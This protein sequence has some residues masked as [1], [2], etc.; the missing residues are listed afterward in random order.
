MSADTATIR[1]MLTALLAQVNELLTD[2][3]QRSLIEHQ[4]TRGKLAEIRDTLQEELDTRMSV[5][6]SE[7][8]EI[9]AARDD[10][11]AAVALVRG[12]QLELGRLAASLDRS[13][14]R[15]IARLSYASIAM[16]AI[17]LGLLLLHH[18]YLVVRFGQAL[19]G[20]GG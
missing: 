5:A 16:S 7:I 8:D 4:N 15:R 1:D 12:V 14:P 17:T 20:S 13:T 11:L 3:E 18:W 9:K 6:F 2:F 10:L 19:I